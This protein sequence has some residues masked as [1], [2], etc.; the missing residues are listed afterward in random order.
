M[1]N[2]SLAALTVLD[3]APPEMIALAARCGY[4]KVGLRLLPATP[5]GMAYRLM[6]DAPLMRETLRR[7]QSTG[8]TVAESPTSK[9]LRSGRRR[10]SRPSCPSSRPARASAPNTSSSPPT[11]RIWAGSRIATGSF[12]KRP[13]RMD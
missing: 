8:V 5:G 10:T 13:R 11:I 4:D 6:E 12:A 2:F 9:S 7:L 1:T 3:L